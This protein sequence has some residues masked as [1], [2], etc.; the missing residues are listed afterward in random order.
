[1][2]RLAVIAI[3]VLSA[4]RPALA[5]T[6]APQTPVIVTQGEAVVK[7]AP[8]RAWLTVATETRDARAAEA[9]RRNAED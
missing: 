6:P 8:D 3:T 9:R 7:R 2:I 4:A 1:M 5:Q